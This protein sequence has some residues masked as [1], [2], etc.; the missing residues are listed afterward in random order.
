VAKVTEG[1]KG[2]VGVVPRQF[3]RRLVDVF[4][5]ASEHDEFD[6]DA[7]L[8]FGPQAPNAD[9]SRKLKGQPPYDPEP[10]D[11]KG[12]PVTPLEF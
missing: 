6:P 12:Y 7:E 8:G 11:D 2:D 5:L 3:L 10:D 4:D 9:E 1:F